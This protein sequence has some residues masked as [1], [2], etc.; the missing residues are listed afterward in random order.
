MI[1]YSCGTH[2]QAFFSDS[3]ASWK[4]TRFDDT[5]RPI[6]T[7]YLIGDTGELDDE[8]LT[9][10]F[11]V[12][13]MSTL[14]S[15]DT[16]KTDVVF[17]GD[18]VY[19][20]G[21]S[22]LMDENRK[23]EEEILK[24]QLNPLSGYKGNIFFIPGNHDWNKH[25]K[26]GREAVIR[27]EQFIEQ[28]LSNQSVNFYP[29]NA[30]GD[31]VIKNIDNGKVFVFLDSQWWMHDWQLEENM[32]ED[33]RIQSRAELLN[34]LRIELKKYSSQNITICLHHPI[35]SNGHHAGRY[36]LLE[37]LFP[38]GK[39]NVWLPLPVVGS[40][41]PL[42]KKINPSNQDINHPQNKRL[43]EGIH[44]IFN[45]LDISATFISGHEHGLQYFQEG[46]HKYIVSGAG[47]KTDHIGRNNGATYARSMRGFARILTYENGELWLEFYTV[48]EAL[49]S[50]AV[51]DFRMMMKGSNK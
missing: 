9:R 15:Q 26:G 22:G 1:F 7:L 51:I 32:N 10:N 47:G 4:T 43:M 13:A 41:F 12:D 30:C 18:N 40:I 42:S 27:Q 45:D 46:R 2:N 38:F 33:C 16:H 17:L 39:Y 20:T 11:T 36:S 28:Y 50:K 37:H 44:E 25:K 34:S 24:A 21:L 5:Q 31:P 23:H 19:P 35:K 29:N 8:E 6:H 3:A 48:K 14:T 49:S